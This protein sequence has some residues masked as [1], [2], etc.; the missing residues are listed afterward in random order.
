VPAPLSDPVLNMG[1]LPGPQTK[2]LRKY[3]KHPYLSI[4][5]WIWRQLEALSRSRGS[6]LHSLIQLRARTQNTGTFFF[7]NRPE[8]ELLL[9]LLNQF[10]HGA[11]V[12]LAVLGC[13]K[14]AEVYSISYTIRTARPDLSL[15]LCALDI[16]KDTLEFAAGGVYFLGGREEA[17]NANPY[18]VEAGGAIAAKTSRHQPPSR[19]MFDRMSSIELDALFERKGSWVRVRQQ[20]RNGIHW[21]L[22]D[23]GNPSLTAKLGSQDIVVANRFLCHMPPDQAEA[24][25]RNLARTVKSG[26]YLF[27]SGVD[28]AV[29]SKVASECGWRPVTELIEEIHEG[30]PSLRRDWPLNYW[31][32]EPLDKS[33]EDWKMRYASVFQLPGPA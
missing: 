1:T 9:R 28:L 17:S 29:R 10:P 14:G 8:L 6:H 19:S 3:L 23:A 30:D 7:R 18:S 33:R 22:G 12:D 13:S 20:F 15:Q 5:T 27:V 11:A 31:G 25:L 2:L 21:N 24:C 26:G 32:L 16:D 4:N